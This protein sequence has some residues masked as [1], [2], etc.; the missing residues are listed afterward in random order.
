MITLADEILALVKVGAEKLT[1]KVISQRLVAEIPNVRA[2]MHELNKSQRAF[3]MRERTDRTLFMTAPQPK[4]RKLLRICCVC[5]SAYEKHA[6]GYLTACSQSCG[7]KLGWEKSKAKRSKQIAELRGTPEARQRQSELSKSFANTPE[8]KEKQSTISKQRWRDPEY[9]AKTMRGLRKAFSD[10]AV[11]DSISK[12]AFARWADPEFKQKVSAAIKRA[13]NKP[14][15]R[16]ERSKRSKAMWADPELRARMSEKLA[17]VNSSPEQR[18]KIA[19]SQKANWDDPEKRRLRIERV[20]ETRAKSRNYRRSPEK[21]EIVKRMLAEGATCKS[22]GKK[23]GESGA[24][25]WAWAK[26]ENL[27]VVPRKER[28][29]QRMAD[30]EVRKQ[31]SIAIS[32]AKR[33]K[34][35]KHNEARP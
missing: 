29:R 27:P 8:F 33:A 23:I 34:S 32:R 12:K 2:A 24:Y 18:Q 1:A 16:R 31:L 20:R 19:K 7:L 14:E 9:R 30:P 28:C 26:A 6:N 3:L 4:G 21:F 5:G 13:T 15:V 11:R 10:E 22:I 35:A 25:V 17:I